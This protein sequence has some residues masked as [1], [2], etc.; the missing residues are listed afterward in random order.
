MALAGQST[1][2]GGPQESQLPRCLLQQ[3]ANLT[4]QVMETRDR[5]R[6]GHCREAA[7]KI[8]R[9]W[10]GFCSQTPMAVRL[11][12]GDRAKGGAV[13]SIAFAAYLGFLPEL[14]C[15][16]LLAARLWIWEQRWKIGK[17]GS[18]GVVGER[19]V[20]NHSI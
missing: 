12:R 18:S 14:S 17:G 7:V 6:Q 8:K 20:R 5:P 1:W 10:A 2:E 3:L 15:L 16:C 9:R 13:A 4:N 19:K 11:E